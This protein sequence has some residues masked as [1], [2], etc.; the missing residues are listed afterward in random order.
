MHA[1][2]R[3][4]PA[5]TLAP[6]ARD[7]DPRAALQHIAQ[8]GFRHVQLSAALPGMRPRDLDRSARRDLLARLRRIELTVAGID[9]WVPV[10]HYT[11]PEHADRA[12]AA[13]LEAIELA[14]DLGR[15]PLSIRLPDGVGEEIVSAWRS[16]GETCGV[17]IADHAPQPNALLGSGIDPAAL[18]AA[19]LDPVALTSRAANLVAARFS[20]YRDESRTTP[21]AGRLDVLAYQVALVSRSFEAPVALDLRRVAD[22]MSALGAALSAWAATGLLLAAEQ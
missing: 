22:P 16:R 18:L 8:S 20:D 15:V 19:G 2:T 1:F 6:L 11:L 14:A 3:L 7:G 21:G 12:A 17:I 10:E 13:V 9:L 5:P 4:A